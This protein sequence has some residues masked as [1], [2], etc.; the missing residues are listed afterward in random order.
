VRWHP[1]VLSF[2]GHDNCATEMG[3]ML[4]HS[5]MYVHIW[6]TWAV[7]MHMHLSRLVAGFVL[8]VQDDPRE[9]VGGYSLILLT[10]TRWE[11]KK[12]KKNTQMSRKSW[13]WW[14]GW[15]RVESF[16]G[17][18]ALC[19]V[20]IHGTFQLLYMFTNQSNCNW[21]LF[22]ILI[23]RLNVLFRHSYLPLKVSLVKLQ[24]MKENLIPWRFVLLS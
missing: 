18:S 9:S 20:T 22:S 1:I 17:E 5:D 24:L 21:Y 14:S 19:E 16:V 7:Q 11:K 4:W 10:Q 8:A 15:S 6:S 3:F 23:G 13:M 12:K 2:F